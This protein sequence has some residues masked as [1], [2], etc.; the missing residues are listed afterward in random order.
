MASWDLLSRVSSPVVIISST[1]TIKLTSSHLSHVWW[2]RY[3]H[4]PLLVTEPFHGSISFSFCWTSEFIFN[5]RISF[6][7]HSGIS[8]VYYFVLCWYS[9][10]V[11]ILSV[12]NFELY[13]SYSILDIHGMV[14]PS[15]ILHNSG[16]HMVFFIL[17]VFS[18]WAFIQYFI[19][20]YRCWYS[21]QL[22][23]YVIGFLYRM[24]KH[25]QFSRTS[26]YR[27]LEFWSW[28][29]HKKIIW[30]QIIPSSYT[31]PNSARRHY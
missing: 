26:N 12:F 6:S 14:I 28:L 1:Y 15:D 24:S 27:I 11:I 31:F 3:D 19:I 5:G 29:Y 18:Y 22:Y 17:S 10:V 8:N 23:I 20:G 13:D 4:L 9:F 16:L 21:L 2:T 7:L 30:L 25:Y